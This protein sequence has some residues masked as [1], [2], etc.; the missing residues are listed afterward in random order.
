[1]VAIVD[2]EKRADWLTCLPFLMFLVFLGVL[3]K[4]KS[5]VRRGKRMR[6]DAV[7]MHCQIFENK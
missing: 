2:L 1:M 4:T 7:F 6:E 3:N 5:C